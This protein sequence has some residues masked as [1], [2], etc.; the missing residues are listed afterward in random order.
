MSRAFELFVGVLR[1]CK[2]SAVITHLT[3]AM[4]K[5]FSD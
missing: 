4:L 5:C 2:C 3:I 1:D